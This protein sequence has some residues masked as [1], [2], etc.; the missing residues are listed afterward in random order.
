MSWEDRKAWP[1]RNAANAA[2]SPT[3]NVT[4]A[5]TAAFA[6]STGVRAGTA[7]NVER[8]CPVV[9]SPET[10]STPSTPKASWTRT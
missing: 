3:T 7:E 9:Y 5:N 10:T 1:P 6:A 4:A 2:T 8:I